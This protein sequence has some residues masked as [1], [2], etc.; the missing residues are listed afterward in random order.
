MDRIEMMRIRMIVAALLLVSFGVGAQDRENPSSPAHYWLGEMGTTLHF[1]G[2]KVVDG[3][4]EESRLTLW[5][6]GVVQVDGRTA[7]RQMLVYTWLVDGEE[8]PGR[9]MAV[10][11]VV[12]DS[13]SASV[14]RQFYGEDIIV[15]EHTYLDLAG[16]VVLG[17]T[18]SFIS[19]MPSGDPH[20]P[21]DLVVH[22]ESEVLETGLTI[23]APAGVFHGCIR[24]EEKGRTR[25]PVRV[26]DGPH[27]GQSVQFLWEGER[28]WAP[29]L[30]S[31]REV[32]RQRTLSLRKPVKVLYE[33]DYMSDLI[34]IEK[35]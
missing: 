32:S 34:E 20:L 4:V 18:W 7:N 23:E 26:V 28:I 33:S 2:T 13:V 35:H 30:G 5:N 12:D 27:A 11:Q 22:M 1:R 6:A 17:H 31:I 3:G 21:R 16:P 25:D 29:G 15:E 8:Y 10:F 9:S 14:G 19:V 24:V